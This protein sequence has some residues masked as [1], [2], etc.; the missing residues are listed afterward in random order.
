VCIKQ[1]VPTT[2]DFFFSSQ[3]VNFFSKLK[4]KGGRS[5]EA[6]ESRIRTVEARLRK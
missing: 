1:K 2:K 6:K 5:Q 3:P 4:G